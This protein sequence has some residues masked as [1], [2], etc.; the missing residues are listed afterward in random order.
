MASVE[1]RLTTESPEVPLRLPIAVRAAAAGAILVVIVA[2]VALH[3]YGVLAR[4]DDIARLIG[5][6]FI[7]AVA[8]FVLLYAT[9]AA[10]GLPTL[11]LNLAAGWLWGPLL[12]GALSALG[13]TVGATVAFQAARTIFGQPL[14]KHMRSK[15]VTWAQAELEQKGW[16]FVAFIRLNPV[17]P[18]GPLNYVFGLTSI[19]ARTYVSATGIALL[20][21]STAVAWIGREV[22]RVSSGP[23][24]AQIMRTAVTVSAAVCVL[25]G[26]RYGAKYLQHRKSEGK[27]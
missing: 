11:P 5:A 10:A 25:A 21:A 6:H 12:G 15:F 27:P 16:R 3:K 20:P 14:R 24:V 22:S 1:P 23:D 4:P 2:A 8:L 19:D 7:S 9:T 18:T 17:F 13:A 26:I